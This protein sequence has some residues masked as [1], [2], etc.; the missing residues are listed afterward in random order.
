VLYLFVKLKLPGYGEGVGVRMF[1]LL[2]VNEAVMGFRTLVLSAE[3]YILETETHVTSVKTSSGFQRACFE[4]PARSE[5][6]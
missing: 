4:N 2:K 6:L 3:P 5:M 1:V